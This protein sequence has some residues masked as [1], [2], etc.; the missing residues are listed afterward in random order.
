MFHIDCIRQWTTP[1]PPEAGQSRRKAQNICPTCRCKILRPGGRG[2]TTKETS[3]F[4]KLIFNGDVI[5]NP[6]SSSS[7][8]RLRR[9]R[10]APPS[11]PPQAV[12]STSNLARRSRVINS[13]ESGDEIDGN[14]NIV[15]SRGLAAANAEEDFTSTESESD[16]ENVRPARP[17]YGRGGRALQEVGA[18]DALGVG[19]DTLGEARATIARKNAEIMQLRRTLEDRADEIQAVKAAHEATQ[20]ELQAIEDRWRQRADEVR[21]VQDALKLAKDERKGFKD[22]LTAEVRKSTALNNSN[23]KLLDEITELKQ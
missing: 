17:V 21:R 10:D 13:V 2:N 14:G 19:N 4:R 6:N 11:S 8:V 18:A 23:R 22:S 1:P 5:I 7:P 20:A 15:Q 12:A 16:G 9:G 3:R